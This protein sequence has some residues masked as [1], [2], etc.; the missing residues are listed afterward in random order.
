MKYGNHFTEVAILFYIPVTLV[1]DTTR[2]KT[3]TLCNATIPTTQ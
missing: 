1:L 2:C 3:C